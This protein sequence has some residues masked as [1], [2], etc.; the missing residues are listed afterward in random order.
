VPGDETG[1]RASRVPRLLDR[2]IQRRRTERGAGPPD[3]SGAGSLV[4]PAPTP[5][6]DP[7]RRLAALERR[8][9]DLESLV[10]GLQDAIHRESVRQEREIQHL[11]RKTDPAEI[12]R[13]LG[14]HARER[15]L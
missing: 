7:E 8:L 6:A 2:M 3:A 14:R 10:E 15:G 11:E 12:A 9:D 4:T 1:R 13:A 5:E